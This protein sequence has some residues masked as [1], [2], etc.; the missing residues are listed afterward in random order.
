MLFDNF[1]LYLHKHINKSQRKMKKE[2]LKSCIVCNTTFDTGSK[3]QHKQ[4]CSK[5]CIGI[6][7]AQQNKENASFRKPFEKKC[8]T[9]NKKFN[10][11]KHK[12][13]L[14]CSS[15]CLKIYQEKHKDSRI[16]KSKK[17]MIEKYGVDHNSHI[18]GFVEKIKSTKLKRFGDENYNNRA[19]A[20]ETCIERYGVENTMQIGEI[21]EKSKQTKLDNHGDENF[22]NRHKAKKTSFEKYGVEHHLQLEEYMNKQKKT[23]KKK[24]GKESTLLIKK[25]IDNAQEATMK[26]FGA[27]FY[28]SSNI[29]LDRQREKSISNLKEKL[30]TNNL[31]FDLNQFEKKI[32]KNKG[33][34]GL[35]HKYFYYEVQCSVC[36]NKFNGKLGF[37]MPICRVCNPF[38]NISKLH[39]E[40]KEFI[41][42][43]NID[44]KENDRSIIKPLELDFYFPK[45]NLAIELNG[46]YFHSEIGGEKNIKYH[47]NKTTLCNSKDIKLIHLFEDEWYYKQEIVKS[48][49]KNFFNKT[50]NK[51]YARKCEIKQLDNNEK[52]TF[53]K[54]N[55]I[56][57]KSSD[58][59]RIGLYHQNI[60]V[61]V[62]TFSKRR[63]ALG[64][65]TT[66]EN[67]YELA[68]FCSLLNTNVVGG[69]E[70]LLKQFMKNKQSCSIITYADCRWSGINP[71]KTVYHKNGFNFLHK[72]RPSYFYMHKKDYLIRHHRFAFNK[73]TLIKEFNGDPSKTEWLLAQ[74]AGFDRIW[75]C[76]TLKFELVK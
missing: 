27:P 35:K 60:L 18:D 76:G 3:H 39:K 26:K 69:F 73:Q 34:N 62:M 33:E 54:E 20:K 13:K 28:F 65:K 15:D 42:S 9:C 1:C 16:E 29:S 70:R 58:M 21:Q 11:G 51:I 75:D 37:I 24:Y 36:G 30:E 53:L 49:I 47:L 45:Y 50:E 22:N 4:T 23:N 71:E 41:D 2:Y 38:D 72:S 25:C 56:Q 61:S 17:G 32:E 14:N 40:F 5:K 8:V 12:E 67:E 31:R 7:R 19:K 64:A 59:E 74:E 6:L 57:G 48:R 46:N 43:L 68:R 44:Y 55:H 10:P 52:N 66:N 63:V